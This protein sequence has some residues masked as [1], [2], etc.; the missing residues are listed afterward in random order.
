MNEF[1]EK[2]PPGG[3]NGMAALAI[4]RALLRSLEKAGVL[5][6]EDVNLIVA[7]ALAQIPDIHNYRA[8][9]ARR[10]VNALTQ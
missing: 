3:A 10:L 5:S 8:Q 9:E 7:D 4:L 2:G 1:A 6:R